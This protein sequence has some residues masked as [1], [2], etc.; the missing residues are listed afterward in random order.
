MRWIQ[1]TRMIALIA[2]V[3]VGFA[4]CSKD[5]VT[6]DNG[7]NPEP[8]S[9]SA[10]SPMRLAPEDFKPTT[11]PPRLTE[12][13]KAKNVIAEHEETLRNANEGDDMYGTLIALA[14]LYRTK[15][16]D[17]ERAAEYYERVVNEY[18]DR[19]GIGNTYADLSWCFTQLDDQDR[20]NKLYLEMMEKFPEDSSEH[21]L[22]KQ[23]LGM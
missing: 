1:W 12:Q 19:S 18:P 13:D 15:F 20:L 3:A 8:T 21:L 22:A 16:K 23:S 7:S 9:G 4:G 5:E 14:N 10:A 6:P 17:L 11:S 2:L